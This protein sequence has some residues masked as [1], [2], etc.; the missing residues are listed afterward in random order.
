[1]IEHP[2]PEALTFDDVLLVPAYS[3]VVPA[4][5]ST[6]TRLTKNILLNTPLLSA[7]MDTVTESR[8]AIAM[9]QQGGLGIIHRNL[10]PGQQASE[11]DKVKRSESGM[12]VDPVTIEPDRPISD[13]LE[14]M[15]R[16]KISGVP[17]TRNKKLVGILTNRDLRFETRT[18]IPIGEVM[19][20][21]NLITVPVGTTLEEAEHILHQ[22]R[23]E[24]LLVVNGDYELRGLITVKDIQKK[25]KYPNA[26]KDEQGRLRVGGAIGATGDFLERAAELVRYRADVLAIDSAHGHSSRV[27]DAVRQVKNRFPAVAL[28]AG[29][30]A[31]YEGAK[32]LIVAGADAVKVGIGPGSICTTRMV[33]GAG[34]PQITAISEAYR[35]GREFGIPIIADGGIK[36]SGDVAKAIAAGAS[37]VMIG[38]LFAGVDESPGETIL[39]QGRSFKAYRGMGSLSAMSQ[40]SGERYF[41]GSQDLGGEPERQESVVAREQSNQNRLAKFVPEGIEGRVPHRGP[42]EAMVYQLV[43]GLRSGMGYLGCATIEEMQT[44]SRF[45]RISNAG[46]RESHVHDVIITREAPNYHVE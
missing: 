24:K 16:Y 11:V 27:L 17:V 34:M 18:D 14:V 45:V 46:L 21:E 6:Q 23:V 26:S 10:T 20:K 36:Y 40:G 32:A 41:Q 3:D 1:M 7:A 25:L 2:L 12:I 8:L 39:Y 19:T 38:S 37:A 13:A 31:T 29:N 28:L 5:V 30:V 9:A 35:A 33:T 15:R 42:L 4:N 43:G 44:K 22:H